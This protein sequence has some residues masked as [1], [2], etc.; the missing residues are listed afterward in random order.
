VTG[1]LQAFLY[2]SEDFRRKSGKLAQSIEINSVL[3]SDNST[4]KAGQRNTVLSKL[5]RQAAEAKEA[6]NAMEAAMLS[7]QK[8]LAQTKDRQYEYQKEMHQ[9]IGQ[10]KGDGR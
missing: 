7:L 3:L 9:S 1:K 4:E 10:E 2:A 8:E 5:C 6:G